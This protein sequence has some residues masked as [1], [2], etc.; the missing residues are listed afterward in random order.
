MTK[1]QV[2]SGG[3]NGAGRLETGNQEVVAIIVGA[4][5]AITAT[6]AINA[7]IIAF[8]M[9]MMQVDIGQEPDDDSEQRLLMGLALMVTLVAFSLSLGLIYFW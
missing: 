7:I 5:T 9:M 3:R 6:N 2:S 4:I 1:T 8:I